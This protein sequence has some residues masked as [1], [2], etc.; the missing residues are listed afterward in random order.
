[1][2]YCSYVA[3]NGVGGVTTIH[4]DEHRFFLFIFFMVVDMC[5]HS[6]GGYRTVI[7]I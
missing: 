3:I 5:V 6:S 1:M 2:I 7:Y 4:D